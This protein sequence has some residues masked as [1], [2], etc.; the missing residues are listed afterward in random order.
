MVAHIF[1]FYTANIF[2]SLAMVSLYDKILVCMYLFFSRTVDMKTH[3]TA[4][5][6]RCCS[7][8]VHGFN[9]N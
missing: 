9:N 5:A 8:K 6:V 3:T 2:G 4:A 1:V 7:G